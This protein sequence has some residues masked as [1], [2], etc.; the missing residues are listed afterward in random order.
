MLA[1][2]DSADEITKHV[3]RLLR[4]ADVGECLPTP[5]EDIVVA[6]GLT[7]TDEIHITE[8]MIRRAPANMQRLLHSAARK[9]RGV[10]HRGEQVIQIAPT[11]SAERER[12]VTCHEITHAIL[13]WQSELAVLGDNQRTLSPRVL[14]LFEREANQGAAEIL[15]QQGL[16][17]RMALDYRIAIST[18]VAL[19]ECFGAS[20]HATFRR[21]TE[22][23]DGVACG[24]VLDTRL[25]KGR[26]RRYEQ[27]L[28]PRWQQQFGSDGFPKEIDAQAFPFAGQAPLEGTLP[29]ID[30]NGTPV[31]LRYEALQTPYR[32]FAL[33]WL[34]QR[35][36][37]VA[38]LR[39]TPIIVSRTNELPRHM[40]L[41]SDAR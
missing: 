22:S 11:N 23:I 41:R 31:E 4:L 3:G 19:A 7:K 36:S 5:V 30:V 25:V 18:P 1:D 32:R 38:R 26:R 16:L 34:P 29:I 27:V 20:I 10:L 14:D 28:T 13:P 6:A 12:F 39:R 8:S 40:G 21:W 15:F 2:L 17:T 33:L 37:L 24:L 35:E 9:I